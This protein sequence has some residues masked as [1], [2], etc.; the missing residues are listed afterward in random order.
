[1]IER[2]TAVQLLN[3]YWPQGVPVDPVYIAQAHG[4]DVRA[5]PL[6]ETQYSG[7]FRLENGRPTIYFNEG[8]AENRRRFTVAHELGHYVLGH[9]ERPRDNAQAFSLNN[10]D[11]REASA[12]KFAAEL[13][14]P[15]SLID[16]YVI[17]QGHSSLTALADI[18]KVS[19]VA[20]QYRLRNL[21]LIR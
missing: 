15:K 8:E 19:E 6:T 14:M 1:M 16:Y 17:Q 12:N 10:Y 7:W 5:F 3:A 21:G 2:N 11:W 13:L 20:M 4:A 18:F 9:G